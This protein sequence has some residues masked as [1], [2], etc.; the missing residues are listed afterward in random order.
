MMNWSYTLLA[1]SL[2]YKSLILLI[3]Y[4]VRQNRINQEAYFLEIV[5]FV[6]LQVLSF[7]LATALPLEHLQTWVYKLLDHD[8]QLASHSSRVVNDEDAR[9]E[10]YLLLCLLKI[11][12]QQ[13]VSFRLL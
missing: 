3:S 13:N 7:A 11:L 8:R 4:I 10:A 9:M 12:P 5:L 6:E 1:C 2:L